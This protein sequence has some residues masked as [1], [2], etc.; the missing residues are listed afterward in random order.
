MHESIYSLGSTPTHRNREQLNTEPEKDSNN[1]GS[2][3][4]NPKLMH[5]VQSN[6]EYEDSGLCS[7]QIDEEMD[8]NQ[9]VSVSSKQAYSPS[10][11]FKR[12]HESNDSSGID[13]TTLLGFTDN[14]QN[15]FG[16]KNLASIVTHATSQPKGIFHYMQSANVLFS[17]AD[18]TAA[19]KSR[20][21]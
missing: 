2:V 3:K 9:Y 6:N 14:S 4:S 15:G 12:Q 5:Y 20:S 11:Q 8:N 10:Q 7:P 16:T 13:K 19:S 17:S 18:R 21:R 1:N